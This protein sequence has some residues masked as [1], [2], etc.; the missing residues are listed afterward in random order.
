MAKSPTWFFTWMATTRAAKEN[1]K[2]SQA[3]TALLRAPAAVGLPLI[4]HAL[5]RHPLVRHSTSI[6]A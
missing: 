6:G 4:V 1:N 3:S 2:T 5:I